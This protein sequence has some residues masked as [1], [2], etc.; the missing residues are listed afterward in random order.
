MQSAHGII[1][2]KGKLLLILRDKHVER[3][4]NKWCLPGGIVEKGERFGQTIRRELR[5]EIG[6]IPQNIEYIGIHTDKIKI[7]HALY[8]II[9]SQ[10]EASSITLGDEGQALKF[11]YLEELKTINLTSTLSRFIDKNNGTVKK[12]LNGNPP[13]LSEYSLSL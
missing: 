11:F 4:P 7:P 6:F 12:I 2:Y 8:Y 10:K 5:E 9:L 1:I 3:D 13:A